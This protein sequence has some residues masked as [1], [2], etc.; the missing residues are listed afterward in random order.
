MQ[1]IQEKIERLRRQVLYHAKRYYVDD[2]PE[3]SDYE[4]DM[5]YAELLRLEAE[6]PA[7]FDPES[8]THRMRHLFK[9][10]QGLSTHTL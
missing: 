3:I 2:D 7:F 5:M 8:P 4:Y 10:V 1:E 9:L 6:N